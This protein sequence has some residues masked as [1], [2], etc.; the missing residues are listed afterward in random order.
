M[1]KYMLTPRGTSSTW[2]P[3]VVA[4]TAATTKT[5]LQ[6]GV[7]STTDILVVGWG[8]SFDGTASSAVPVVCQL[9]EGAVAATGTSMTP[10]TWGNVQSGASLCVGGSAATMINGTAEG[11]I[12][13]APRVL[14]QQHV[15]PQSGYGVWWTP[16]TAPTCGTTAASFVRIRCKAPA[17]VNVLPWISWLEPAV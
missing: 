9:I 8:V 2:E 17:G 12:T 10:E 4:L 7:P 3:T 11:T 16:S 15:H 13:G 5:V 6:V 14:D 1:S